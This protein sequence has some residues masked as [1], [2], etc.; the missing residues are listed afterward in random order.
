M[1]LSLVL[2]TVGFVIFG[3][4]MLMSASGP[5]AFQ[6]TGDSLFF[7]KRQILSG[8]LPGFFG[9]LFFAFVDYRRFRPLAFLALGITL[10]LLVLVYVP[11]LGIKIRGAQSWLQ[12]GFLTFQPS[13]LVKFTFLIYLAAWLE[14]RRGTSAHEAQT[15]LLPFLCVLGAVILLLVLQP[16]TGS[17]AVIVGTALALY[18]LS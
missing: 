7:V 4:I 9:F 11:G 17:M 16:D 10:L 3:L 12:I 8:I 15:G 14:K 5:T 2:L 6:Q 1:D 13:E 18:F